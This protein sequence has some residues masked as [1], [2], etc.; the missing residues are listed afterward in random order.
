MTF[1]EPDPKNH[2]VNQDGISSRIFG[3]LY[4][5]SPDE[6][7]KQVDDWIDT[8]ILFRK[9]AI[10]IKGYSEGPD[11]GISMDESHA[12]KVINSIYYNYGDTRVLK[13][14]YKL[15]DEIQRAHSQ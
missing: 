15:E 12:L 4:E 1:K 13:L 7:L 11:Y 5:D 6:W 9:S 10:T 3:V 14:K 8:I 2:L